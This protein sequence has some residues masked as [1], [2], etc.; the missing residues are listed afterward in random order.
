MFQGKHKL[1]IENEFL[2]NIIFSVKG[3]KT[4]KNSGFHKN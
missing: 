2:E 1:F 4:A 3:R